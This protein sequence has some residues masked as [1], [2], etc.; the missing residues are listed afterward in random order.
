MNSRNFRRSR[1]TFNGERQCFVYFCVRGKHETG[2]GSVQ[3]EQKPER[4]SGRDFESAAQSFPSTFA[5]V[6]CQSDHALHRI[7]QRPRTCP[8]GRKIRVPDSFPSTL[9]TSFHRKQMLLYGERRGV[10]VASRAVLV[11]FS[12]FLREIFSS[13]TASRSSFVLHLF[14]GR[15]RGMPRRYYTKLRRSF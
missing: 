6:F 15:I 14:A 2:R 1:S 7:C 10:A 11:K 9:V 13:V 4:N 8:A 5:D 12:H 3:P